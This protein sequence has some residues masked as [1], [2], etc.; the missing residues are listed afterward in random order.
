MTNRR[1]YSIVAAPLLVAAVGAL[2]G[3]ADAAELMRPVSQR[4]T[5]APEQVTETPDFQRHVL[6]LMGRLGCN[7]RACHG[8]FQGQGGFRLSLFGYD[9]KMDHDALLKEGAS[10]VLVDNPEESKILAKP[11]LAIPHKGG[12]KLEE[13]TWQHTILVRWIEQ[14]AKGVDTSQSARFERL[15][16]IPQEIVFEREGQTV[17]MKVIAHWSDGTAEDVTCITRYRTNDESIAEIDADGV[18]TS[19]G[20]GDTHVVAFYDNGVAVT[21]VILPVTDQVGPRYPDV[22]TPTR[23]DELVV[24]KLR[25]LG[26]VPSELS[27]DAEFLRRVSLDLTG[28]LPTPSEIEAFLA[29]T[30]SAKRDR[31]IDELLARPSYAAWWT[32]KLCDMTGCS[33]TAFQNQGP[34]QQL[35]RQWYEWIYKRVAENVPYDK[36]VAGIVLATSR[37]PGQSYEDFCKEQSAFFRDKDPVDFAAHDTMPYYWAKRLVRKPEEKALNFSYTF[38]GVRLEVRPVPQ[39]PVRSVDPGRLQSVHAP[40]SIDWPTASR[41]K[42]ASS[43]RAM[44]SELGVK[45]MGGQLQRELTRLV[46]EGKIIPWQ[47]VFIARNGQGR[48]SQG[49]KVKNA[50]MAAGR[51]ITPKLL[52]GDSVATEAGDDPASRSWTGSVRGPTP[53]SPAPWSTASGPITSGS[54]SSTRPMI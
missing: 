15:E 53:I 18:V 17:P 19:K 31:K 44:L 54:A 11:T 26:I 50:A 51:V 41:P 43:A 5:G 4:Y 21:Q 1:R 9:F 6:P 23:V 10:R 25:K 33:A 39:A 20:K 35:A 16:V 38:L 14:G 13:G 52:G 40:S 34:V 45:Q 22:P 49:D 12:K 36:I 29:D 47:E 8:S 2:S 46:H 3:R 30:S 7:G 37:K 24:T 27:D 48:R 32:T 28:S 42:R